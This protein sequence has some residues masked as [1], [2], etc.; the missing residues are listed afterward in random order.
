MNKG[1]IALLLLTT[2]CCCRPCPPP[3]VDVPGKWNHEKTSLEGEAD[4]YWW[5]QF[6]DPELDAYIE[7][8]LRDNKDIKIAAARVG[9]F[10]EQWRVVRSALFPFLTGQ[11][12]ASRQ[13]ASVDTLPP[14]PN[15]PRITNNF[16]AV[17]NLNYELD[18][19]GRVRSA[20]AAAQ[21]DLYQQIY[22][23]RATVQSLVGSI[24]QAYL[25]LRQFDEQLAISK[26]TLKSRQEAL[27]IAELRFEESLTSEL[28][29][30]QAKSEVDAAR[31]QVNNFET[32]VPQQEDLLSILLGRNPQPLVRGKNLASMTLPSAIPSGLP[33]DLLY[34]R[35]DILEAEE[36]LSA[37]GYRIN[38][39][40]AAYFPQI[41]LTG[42]YGSESVSLHRLFTGPTRTWQYGAQA[43]QPIFEGGLISA[44]VEEAK[45]VRVQALYNYE[46]TI[47]NAF[48]EVED[49]LIAHQQSRQLLEIQRSQVDNFTRYLHLAS[50]RYDNG[51]T[52]YLN[53]LDAQRNLFKAQLDFVSAESNNF[54]TAINLY[55][56]LGGS[57]INA[58]DCRALCAGALPPAPPPKG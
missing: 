54:I 5:H 35:P 48:R 10:Y 36:A 25:Q 40:R 30:I 21:A 43:V 49:A 4:L 18:L 13:E 32:L 26:T 1:W 56:A 23:R 2:G 58:A 8:G 45:W 44:Q 14:L 17:L 29:V 50:V 3:C 9:Q 31:A 42:L 52:D 41:T 37:A 46:K 24:A 11:F 47:Q 53:V 7:E 38:E 22:V 55:L 28:E 16:T 57:W 34:R 27:H 12:Q 20:T 39:A 6:G 15:I 33:S 19:W 51:E